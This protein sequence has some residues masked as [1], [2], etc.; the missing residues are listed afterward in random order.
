MSYLKTSCFHISPYSLLNKSINIKKLNSDD[1][2]QYKKIR[3]ELLKNEPRNFG[4]SF[5]EESKFDHDMWKNRLTK[6]YIAV[7]GGFY[8]GERLPGNDRE[9]F[10]ASWVLLLQWMPTLSVPSEST[11]REYC[12]KK[13]N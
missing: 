7:F 5:E 10:G 13:R 1:L 11:K 6:D 12:F 4:S 8:N 9:L 2:E 3:L